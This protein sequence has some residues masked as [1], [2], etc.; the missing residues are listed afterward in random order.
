MPIPLKLTDLMA[1][2]LLAVG[3][4]GRFSISLPPPFIPLPLQYLGLFRFQFFLYA[5]FYHSLSHL[6]QLLSEPFDKFLPLFFLCY[7]QFDLPDGYN[8][9]GLISCPLG[10]ATLLYRRSSSF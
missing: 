4:T 9:H 10:C 8:K 7:L 5:P 2:T 6:V 3:P 1:P